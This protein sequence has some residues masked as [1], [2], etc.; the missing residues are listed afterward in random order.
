MNDD[1]DRVWVEIYTTRWCGYCYAAK[2]LLTKR[3]IPFRETDVG[4]NSAARAA[5]VAKT[6]WPTVPVI[7]CRG[8]LIGGYDELATL[9]RTV[10]LDKLRPTVA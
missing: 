7:L 4:G 3:G 1:I 8:E 10:G 5:I 9:D 2:R 6:A